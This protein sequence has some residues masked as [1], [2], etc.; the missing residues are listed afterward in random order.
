MAGLLGGLAL[1]AHPSFTALLPG[2]AGF[3]LLRGRHLFRGIQVYLAGLVALGAFANVL[4]Y[5][6]QSGIGG[7]RSVSRE[8]PDEALG[9]SVYV[10]NL[11]APVR[12]IF[13]SLASSVDPTRLTTVFE[14]F[15]LFVATL[16]LGALLYLAHRVTILP[17]LVVLSAV[18]LLP[19]LHDDFDPLFKARYTMPLIPLVFVAIAVL[20]TRILTSGSRLSRFA[21]AAAG[22]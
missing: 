10:E 8:Y 12:G 7:L 20:L 2:F 3:L 22:S 5:N 17:I 21:A 15:V 16:S 13:L 14:P 11:D 18:L 9:L 19:F 4:L 6:W 1:Q